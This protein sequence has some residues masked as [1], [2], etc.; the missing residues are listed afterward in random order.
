M[1]IQ[2]SDFTPDQWQFLANL[3]AC[4]MPI[5]ISVSNILTPLEPKL[6]GILLEQCEAAGWIQITKNRQIG[7]TQ[8]LPEPTRY[9]LQLLN[10]PDRISL[11]L[12]KIYDKKSVTLNWARLPLAKMK[13]NCMR[14]TNAS[15]KN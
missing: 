15:V 7:L 13:T 8:A 10:T 1:N 2:L 4:G 5:P 3:E 12:N 14:L 6:L 9:E 11:L